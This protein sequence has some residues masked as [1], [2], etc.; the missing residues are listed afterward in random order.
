MR[1]Q[2]ARTIHIG[3]L[4]G[5]HI[6]IVKISNRGLCESVT[7][8]NAGAIAQ[9][10]SGWALASLRGGRLYRFPDDL[11]LSPGMQV[12]IHS[13]QDA[14]D[15][16]PLHLFWTDDQVWNNRGDAAVL[17]DPDGAE[18]DRYAYGQGYTR[19]RVV[20]QRKQLI[21]EG[22]A[23]NIVDELVRPSKRIVVRRHPSKQLRQPAR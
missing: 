13:G 14:Q 17:F 15:R 22:K 2:T 8:A 12:N 5:A 11:V 3:M 9:P 1:K 23:W 7:P 18:V 20:R 21:R 16:P 6:K 19:S 4:P 10:L